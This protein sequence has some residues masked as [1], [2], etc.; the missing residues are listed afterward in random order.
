MPE[1][2]LSYLTRPNPRVAS[3]GSGSST[4][5]FNNIWSPAENMEP[6]DEFTYASLVSAFQHDFNKTVDLNDPTP[7]CEAA[8]LHEIYDENM[9]EH[10]VASSIMIPVS[11]ALPNELFMT[12]GARTWY[13]LD[14]FPDWSSGN[15]YRTQANTRPRATVLGDTKYK[16]PHD[17]AIHLIRSRPHGYEGF[18]NRSI[19]WPIEQVQFYCA[20]CKCRFGFLITEKGLLAL[21]AY[22]DPEIQRSPRPKRNIQPQTHQRISSLSTVDMS[23]SEISETLT[24]MSIVSASLAPPSIRLLKYAFVPLGASGIGSLTVKLGL[25]FL[26]R[27]GNEDSELR[28]DYPPLVSSPQLPTVSPRQGPTP[29]HPPGDLSAAGKSADKERPR[30]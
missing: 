25:Y 6:W 15:K 14:G 23:V 12:G 30:Q 22:Q 9:L 27:M 3:R 18:A 11:S 5:T 1:T 4:F 8:G 16:W 7:Q 24:D 20:S 13:N 29:I 28:P 2:L 26:A 21:Q 10:L 17:D 19:V